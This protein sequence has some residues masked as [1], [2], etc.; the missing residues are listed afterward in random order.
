MKGK[1]EEGRQGVKRG[2]GRVKERERESDGREGT[3]WRD[4]GKVLV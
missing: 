1:K 3:K 2:S 4:G